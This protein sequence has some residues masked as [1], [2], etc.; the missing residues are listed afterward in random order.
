MNRSALQAALLEKIYFGGKDEDVWLVE[1]VCLRALLTQLV[2][3]GGALGYTIRLDAA[4]ARP[5]NPSSMSACMVFARFAPLSS[6]VIGRHGKLKL[7]AFHRVANSPRSK[8]SHRRRIWAVQFTLPSGSLRVRS[9]GAKQARPCE[10]ELP[11]S[12]ALGV[13]FDETPGD[14]KNL[15]DFRECAFGYEVNG[16]T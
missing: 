3:S 15:V 7:Y 4:T 1:D 5:G 10:K 16:T 12:K 13:G 6:G 8:D 9:K 2:G 11:I 14:S